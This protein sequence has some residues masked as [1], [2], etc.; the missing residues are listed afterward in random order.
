MENTSAEMFLVDGQANAGKMEW[1]GCSFCYPAISVKLLKGAESTNPNQQHTS[2]FLCPQQDS[3]Q[4]G[5]CS[6]NAGSLKQVV[7]DAVNEC[8]VSTVLACSIADL[9][10]CVSVNEVKVT[11]EG[12]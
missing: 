11:H 3:R 10:I 1:A 12:Q 2:S 9:C 8:K 5:Y 6:L 4:N 7:R